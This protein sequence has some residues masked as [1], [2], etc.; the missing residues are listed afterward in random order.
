MIKQIPHKTRKKIVSLKRSRHHSFVHSVHKKHKISYRTLTYMK[1]YGPK[2]HVSHVIIRESLKVLILASVISSIGGVGLNQIQSRLLSIIPLV[3]LLPAL[4]DMVG[5]YGTTISSKF[6]N[7]LYLG[8]IKG[9]WWKS[10]SVR[11][12][13]FTMFLISIISSIYIG[14]LSYILAYVKGF[15]FEISVLLKIL[16]LSILS[17][18]LLVCLIFLISVVGGI[19]IYRKGEDPNNFLIP[20]TTS[21]GD[22]GSMLLFSWMVTLLF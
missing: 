9:R 11:S 2:S 5:D 7:M 1:E 6:T 13:F 16:Q 12:L 21:V 19:Y 15:A 8:K 18:T 17:A 3:I 20:I 10:E 14:F 22:I 4:S